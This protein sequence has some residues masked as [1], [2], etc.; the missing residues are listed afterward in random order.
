MTYEE[1][2]EGFGSVMT[3]VNASSWRYIPT[4]ESIKEYVKSQ[5]YAHINPTSTQIDIDTVLWQLNKDEQ[6]PGQKVTKD[7]LLHGQPWQTWPL[8]D[9]RD[10]ST[11]PTPI[12]P[13]T[14][15]WE[16]DER[17]SKFDPDPFKPDGIPDI[18]D[19]IQDNQ[20]WTVIN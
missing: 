14:H 7:D 8:K 2:I 20:K 10:S 6:H 17:G 9:A 1:Y 16:K 15:D 13:S 3:P 19:D 4:N 11:S 12:D 18:I 5:P